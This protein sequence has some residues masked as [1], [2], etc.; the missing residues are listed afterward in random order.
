M[1]FPPLVEPGGEL[2]E[3]Q[4]ERYARHLSLPGFGELGQ[5]RLA[6][7]RILIVGA[8][9]LGCPAATYLVAAGVGEVGLVDDDLVEAS[10]LQRQVL[11]GPGDVGRPKVDSAS[12]S[13][14]AQN[15]GV[16]LVP[17]R[18]R[19]DPG[20]AREVF[21]GWDLVLDCTDN[22]TTRYLISDTA[23]ALGLPVVWGSVLG[24]AGQVSV[25][26][27]APPAPAPPL[28]LR[29]VFPNPPEGTGREF[30]VAGILGAHVGVVGS[31]MAVEALKLVTGCGPVRF[32][33]IAVVDS[34]SGGISEVPFARVATT[35][36][37]AT[38]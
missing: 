6:A 12:E 26:W 32:G 15:P 20:N 10:N 38:A 16:R 2:T 21:A 37:G 23:A 13:L 5:R 7:A 17:R 34:F 29:S 35:G 36:G 30:E 28:T 8:G 1:R 31:L 3:A 25:F 9:G 18:L 4:C 22:F 19:L 33:R 27:S 11:H 14:A 24:F